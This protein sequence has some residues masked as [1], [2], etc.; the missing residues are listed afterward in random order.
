VFDYIVYSFYIG[1][2]FNLNERSSLLGEK[3]AQMK[4]TPLFE[5]EI[6]HYRKRKKG[7]AV[8][9]QTR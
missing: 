4:K 1:K 8:Q 7:W 9:K 2:C 6:P 3:R 5:Y